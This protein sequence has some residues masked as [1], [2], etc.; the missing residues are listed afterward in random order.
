MQTAEQESRLEQK[1]IDLSVGIDCFEGYTRPHGQLIAS[2]ADRIGT[3]LGMA[4]HDRFYM[5]QAALVHDIG[6]ATMDRSYIRENRS[7]SEDE[8][9]DLHRHP[10]IGEQEA[11]KIGLARGVQLLVRWHHEWW[12][13]G[14]YPDALSG[15]QIPLAARILR[16]SDSFAAMMETRPGRPNLT[17]DAARKEIAG[18]AAIEFD[19]TIAKLILEPELLRDILEW[20]ATAQLPY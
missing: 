4:A 20:H 19:P 12:N 13:G 16:A 6:E 14:G 3:R 9:F 15:E 18:L 7:L 2:I 17:P 11:A 8:R 10:V 5:Q 1:L